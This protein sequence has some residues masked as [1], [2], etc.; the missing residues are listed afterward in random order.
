MS[1]ILSAKDVAA[2][3]DELET[4][5]EDAFRK[6]HGRNPPPRPLEVYD[7][8]VPE[9]EDLPP[10]AAS[11]DTGP[12]SD[13]ELEDQEEMADLR[14]E[15]MTPEERAA[16][17]AT[18]AALKRE[19]ADLEGALESNRDQDAGTPRGEDLDK[20]DGVYS[21]VVDIEDILDTYCP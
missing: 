19:L 14:R 15:V 1:N 7:G 4:R 5:A 12:M 9:E 11:H 17:A 21:R 3:R 2:L 18:L 8:E 10:P 6:K 20:R 13:Q 16:L